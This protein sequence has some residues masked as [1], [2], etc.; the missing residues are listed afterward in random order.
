MFVLVGSAKA[1]GLSGSAAGAEQAARMKISRIGMSF[2]ITFA[3]YGAYFTLFGGKLFGRVVF[4]LTFH[5][6][7][8][9]NWKK[10]DLF[11]GRNKQ[12]EHLFRL[13]EKTCPGL[14]LAPAQEEFGDF[15][16]DGW[17]GGETEHHRPFDTAH[18][19]GIED[20]LEERH[21]GYYDE[22]DR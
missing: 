15:F 18:K 9:S 22:Q 6:L 21:H 5:W 12:A 16:S 4:L 20:F 11:G 14:I 2:L 7:A 17:N 1:G 19:V 13:F 3:P 10:V 8:G